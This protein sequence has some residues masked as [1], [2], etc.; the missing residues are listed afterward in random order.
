MPRVLGIDPGSRVTGWGVLEGGAGNASCVA[1]GTIRAGEDRPLGERLQRIHERLSEVIREFGPA[2]AA[3]ERVF[4]NRNVDSAL[5]LGHARGVVVLAVQQGGVP[6]FEYTPAQVKR[7]VTGS[8]RAEKAQVGFLVKTLLRL[9]EVP[10]E[11]AADALAIAWTHLLVQG[12]QRVLGGAGGGRT[13]GS[14]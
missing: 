1:W 10:Q 6:L 3:L 9:P 14:G 2:A 8:G 4:L 11:D 12:A 7:L 13:G 5:K